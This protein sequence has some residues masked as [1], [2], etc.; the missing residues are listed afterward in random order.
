MW[1]WIENILG[2]LYQKFE[3]QKYLYRV[4]YKLDDGT[5]YSEMYQSAYVLGAL[6]T[7]LSDGIGRTIRTETDGFLS[8]KI[9]KAIK[10]EQ[11]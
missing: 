2:W 6:R 7:V 5:E 4:T 9:I 10:V 11:I 8:N 3:M 1:N